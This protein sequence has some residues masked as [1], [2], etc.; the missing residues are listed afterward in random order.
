M[1]AAARR[2]R[3]G[4]SKERAARS[5]KR[6]D[7]VKQ[8][9]GACEAQARV[10]ALVAENAGHQQRLTTAVTTV[11]EISGDKTKRARELAGVKQALEKLRNQLVASQKQNN[12]AL[13][14]I[15]APQSTS[16]G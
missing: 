15:N 1:I 4:R 12:E 9:K 11:R 3:P 7:A 5:E 8:V 2:T 6:D 13:I 10:T 14:P 16:L